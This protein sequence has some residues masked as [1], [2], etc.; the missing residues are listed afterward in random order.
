MSFEPR[1]I[2]R[3]SPNALTVEPLPKRRYA[4]RLRPRR[5][6]S[7]PKFRPVGIDPA[8]VR[9]AASR[10]RALRSGLQ[11]ADRINS[12]GGRDPLARDRA[13]TGWS[14]P[15]SGCRRGQGHSPMAVRSGDVTA[16]WGGRSVPCARPR[17]RLR[18][19][20][21]PLA[22]A[23]ELRPCHTWP[24]GRRACGRDREHGR[25]GQPSRCAG[26]GSQRRR[27]GGGRRLRSFPS[28]PMR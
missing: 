16:E 10:R 25:R 19:R 6:R 22:P 2:L 14:G 18:S 9:P 4:A 28:C 27:L 11:G 15:G 21:G 1:N 17:L 20:S 23:C 13:Q 3:Q 5:G 12:A 24:D 26:R 7:G 8:A